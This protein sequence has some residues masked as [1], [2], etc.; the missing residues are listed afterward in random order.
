MAPKECSEAPIPDHKHVVR[1]NLYHSDMTVGFGLSSKALLLFRL[2]YDI[3]DQR[4][5]YTTL[6][7]QPFVPPYGDIHHRT[8]T[9]YGFS[10]ADLM[11]L[12][13]P[14]PDWLVGAGLTLPIGKTQPDP[15]A[16][17]RL[18]L[19]HEHIQFGSGTVDPRLLVDWSHRFGQVALEAFADA[20]LPLY[21]NGHGYK[22]PITVHYKVGP[23]MAFGSTG[24]TVAFAGQYQ[25]IARWS[26]E[27]DEGTG[28]VN[29]GIFVGASIVLGNGFRAVP[30]VYREVFSHS[31]SSQ[32]SFRQGTTWSLAISRVFM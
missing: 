5:R 27:E 18:G 8:E 17:G 6:D 19:T 29:G 26:G 28:F 24:V 12:D 25:T 3:K 14:S 21:E 22:A 31:L 13:S 16:L 2:P 11:A 32:Q 7:G 10:D 15:I 1:M 4:V 23:G 20:R 9:L 30:G